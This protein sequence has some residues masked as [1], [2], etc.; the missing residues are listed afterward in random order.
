ML[1]TCSNCSGCSSR[2][3]WPGCAGWRQHLSFV[4]PDTVVR[5][6]RQ[7][8]R[9]F[10]RWKSRS[11]GGRPHLSLEIR[12]LIVTMSRENRLWGTERIRGGLLKLGIVVSNRSIRRYRWRGPARAPSQTWRTFLRNHAHHLWVADLFTEPTIATPVRSPCANA[13]VERV[14]G[15]LRRQCLDQMIVLAE[16][17]LLSVLR[18]F[19]TYYN[20]ERPH[21]TL[22]FRRPN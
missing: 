3:S 15:T 8:W 14:I 16:R 10:W 22:R 17:H 9:L 7:S 19:V 20:Q 21:R 6:H 11:R 4:T 12:D 2:P 18:E 1:R 5:W 13:I